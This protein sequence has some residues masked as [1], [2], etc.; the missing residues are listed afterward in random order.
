MLLIG[1]DRNPDSCRGQQANLV[2]IDEA[3]FVEHLKY[4]IDSVIKPALML[5]GGR[6]FIGTTPP[7][8]EDH[9]F[10]GYLAQAEAKGAVVKKTI[11][12]C[13]RL[14]P[15]QIADAMEDAGGD[16]TDSWKREY[17]VQ[18]IRNKETTVLIEFDDKAMTDIVT[19]VPTVKNPFDKYVG[20]D[21][22]FTDNT[23]LVFGYYDFV[24]GTVMIQREMLIEKENTSKIANKIKKLE[25]DIWEAEPYRRTADSNNPQ[26]IF[27]LSDLHKLVFCPDPRVGT[28]EQRIN[29]VRLMIQNRQIRIDPSCINLITQMRFCKWKNAERASFVRTPQYGHFDL[30]DALIIMVSNIDFMRNPLPASYNIHVQANIPSQEERHT[31]QSLVSP[32]LA[33]IRRKNIWI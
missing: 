9:D 3:G 12:D 6:I 8:N 2:I 26:L 22:G 27:D 28:K 16:H 25:R 33:K 4:L 31:L 13:P 29:R 30:V 17:L 10:L 11:Y 15:K 18:I 1:S 24:T 21:L 23:G 5:T 14:T 20:M 19:P 7:K 32:K